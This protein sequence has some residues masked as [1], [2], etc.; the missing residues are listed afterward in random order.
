MLATVIN[1]LALQSV[2]ERLGVPT[3]VQTAIEMRELAEPFI[4]RKLSGTS[5][6]GG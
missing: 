3:R 2:L 4:R 1:A 6:R 5:R